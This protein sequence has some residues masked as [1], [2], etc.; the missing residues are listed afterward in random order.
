MDRIGSL[1]GSTVGMDDGL[2][3]GFADES[4]VGRLGIAVGSS[5]G[6]NCPHEST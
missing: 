5:V 6:T 1:V 4:M 2:D 3:V